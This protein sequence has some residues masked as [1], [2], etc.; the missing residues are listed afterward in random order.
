MQ[1][2]WIGTIPTPR[3]ESDSKFS[4]FLQHSP[5]VWKVGHTLIGAV[6]VL[7]TYTTIHNETQ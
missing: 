6:V 5:Q 2:E 3:E 7:T 4:T 1:F